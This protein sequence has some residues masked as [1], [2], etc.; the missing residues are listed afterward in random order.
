MGK[1]FN[2]KASVT[3]ELTLLM[4][5][6]IAVFLFLFYT[7]YYLHDI[8]AVNKGISTA[9]LRGS[10]ALYEDD[11]I[12]QM[13]DAM[14]DIRLLGKWDIVPECRKSGTEVELSV[15]GK[16]EAAEGLFRKAVSG[17]YK[18]STSKGAKRIDEVKYIRSYRR[19]N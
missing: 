19:T 1:R 17:E 16:M 9:L 7:S 12:P 10:L 11:I 18:Y 8:V 4:P 3:V 14:N 13:E 5:M 2:V 6:I 15:S